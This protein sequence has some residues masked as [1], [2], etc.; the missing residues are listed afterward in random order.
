MSSK[1]NTSGPSFLSLTNTEEILRYPFHHFLW[2]LP[3]FSDTP[4]CPVPELYEYLLLT[5][6]KC[7][8]IFFWKQE[9]HITCLN[10]LQVLDV[11][12]SLCVGNDVAVRSNQN[13]I[14]DNL[15][16][17][18]DL[19]LQTK[20]VDYVYRSVW[21]IML[22][23]AWSML[24]MLNMLHMSIVWHVSVDTCLHVTDVPGQFE[25]G[26][27]CW[28]S[29]INGLVKIHENSVFFGPPIPLI[30]CHDFMNIGG[31]FWQ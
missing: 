26:I 5:T 18:R 12:C 11:L 21:L 29:K 2:V 19:L 27:P 1:S 10:V 22:K 6:T 4:P 24:N 13:L 9:V 7:H 28:N 8:I 20:V 23:K 25:I 30:W 14:C 3:N 15:L 17:S 31:V 16:P